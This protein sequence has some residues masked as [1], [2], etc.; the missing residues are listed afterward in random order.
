LTEAIRQEDYWN[1]HDEGGNAAFI[2]GGVIVCGVVG[3]RR[4][5]TGNEMNHFA[6]G[7]YFAL[8][9]NRDICCVLDKMGADA[10]LI[11]K[12]HV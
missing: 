12:P 10:I 6:I 1:V 8:Y 5:F 2:V 3:R 11:F 7:Y 9:R 4:S